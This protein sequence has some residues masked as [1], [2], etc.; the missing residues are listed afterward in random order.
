MRRA[1]GRGFNASN[2]MLAV[3]DTVRRPDEKPSGMEQC[4]AAVGASVS[5]GT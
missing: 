5:E 4:L 1:E 2:P 3:T